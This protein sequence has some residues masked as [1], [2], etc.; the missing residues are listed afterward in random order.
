MKRCNSGSMNRR[1]FLQTG[2]T[3]AAVL[4]VAGALLRPTTA[5]AEDKLV[6][7]LA[8]AGDEMA[9]SLVTALGYVAISEKEDENCANCLFYEPGAGGTGKC[10]LMPVPGGVVADAAWCTSFSKKT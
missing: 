6:T 10:Q 1:E 4:P 3:A 8:A 9:A 5:R 7:E 2:L